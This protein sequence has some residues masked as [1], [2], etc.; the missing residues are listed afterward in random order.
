MDELARCRAAQLPVAPVAGRPADRTTIDRSF[1][2]S[3]GDLSHE[4][5]AD[6]FLSV[7]DRLDAVLS[8]A[9]SGASQAGHGQER[10]REAV[11]AWSSVM[12]GQADRDTPHLRRAALQTTV[13]R[14]GSERPEPAEPARGSGSTEHEAEDEA[15]ASI[16]AITTVDSL[17][18]VASDVPVAPGAPDAP[19]TPAPDASRRDVDA[20]L[21]EVRGRL[22]ARR[23]ALASDHA[24]VEPDDT[25]RALWIVAFPVA[26]GVVLGVVVALVETLL[27]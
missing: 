15:D 26:V 2:S 14:L 20:R 4:E 11:A 1:G 18:P 5:L 3:G 19:L 7:A 6:V 10:S 12:E 13:L 23:L 8:E 24:D 27:R 16:T 25:R 22:E 17:A 21:G 9:S